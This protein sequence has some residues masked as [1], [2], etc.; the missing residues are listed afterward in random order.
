MSFDSICALLSLF[1][2]VRIDGTVDHECVTPGALHNPSPKHLITFKI[3]LLLVEMIL[4]I[5]GSISSVLVR[6]AILGAVLKMTP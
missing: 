5:G 2:H 3:L 6:I 1:C 4:K